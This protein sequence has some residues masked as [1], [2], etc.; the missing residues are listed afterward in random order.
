MRILAAADTHGVMDVYKWIVESAEEQQADLV[1]LAGDL[2]AGDLEAGQSKQA[3][4]I[5]TILRKLSKPLFYLMGNDDSVPL[6]YEDSRI[7]PLHRRRLDLGGYSF[8]GY[9]YSLPFVGGIFEK[10]ESEIEKDVQELEPWLDGMTIF[11]THSPAYGALDRTYDG[12]HVGSRSLAALLNRKPVLAHVH[13][14]IHESF[15]R[16]GIHFNVAAAGR[17][18]SFV[19]DFP[20]LTHKIVQGD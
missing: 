16:D 14:H 3:Q 9:Q 5:T 10:P 18:R 11:V 13:G 4:D 1:L 2:F 12:C 17:R 15:G 7:K 6:D 8:V 20:S 19:I